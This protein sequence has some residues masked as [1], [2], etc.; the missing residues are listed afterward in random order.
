MASRLRYGFAIVTVTLIAGFAAARYR[1][2]GPTFS[3]I[4]RQI[5]SSRPWSNLRRSILSRHRQDAEATIANYTRATGA[6]PQSAA[7]EWLNRVNYYRTMVKLPPIVEDPAL[8][9]GDLAHTTYIVRNYRDAIE[10]DGLGAQMHTEDPGSPGFTPE[11]LE[12]AKSS[13]MD[14][15]SMRGASADGWGTPAWSIDGW[16][17]LPFHR[18]PILNPNLT[19]AGFGLYCEAG[20]CAAGLNLLKG[21]EGKMPAAAAASIADRVP[22]ER[23]HGWNKV[24]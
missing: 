2:I 24:V 14:V 18:M 13:D 8:S 22:A 21:A 5:S 10:R 23:R 17:A 1:D 11:G 20:A 9:R 7:P 6:Y 16:M 4:A 3:A 19:S 15:W 12:A